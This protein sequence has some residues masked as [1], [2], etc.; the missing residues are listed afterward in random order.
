MDLSGIDVKRSIVGTLGIVAAIG[1]IGLLGPAGLLAGL[2]AIF[3]GVL[4]DPEPLPDRLIARARFVAIGA[5]AVGLLAWSGDSVGWATLVASLVTFVGTLAAG[6]G[7][8][9]QPKDSSSSS[10]RS[11]P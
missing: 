3:L 4:D 1:F 5:L 8:A 2:C 7:N 9:P 6:W 11:S 10:S